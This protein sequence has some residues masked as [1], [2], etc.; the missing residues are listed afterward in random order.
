MAVKL[1]LTSYRRSS[2]V[3]NFQPKEHLFTPE[4]FKKVVKNVIQEEDR[5]RNLMLFGLQEES[6]EDLDQ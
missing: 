3:Q 1:P 5:S 6:D 4:T 2:A